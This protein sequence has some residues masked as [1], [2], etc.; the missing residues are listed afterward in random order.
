MRTIS[1]KNRK[2]ID[3]DPYFKVCARSGP[4]CSK[5]ITIEH[6]FIHAGRQIDELFNFLPLCT[7][8]HAV[9]EHQDGGD[10]NKELNEYLALCRATMPDLIKYPRVSW[11]LRFTYLHNKFANLSTKPTPMAD[12]KPKRP[13][14]PFSFCPK[15]NVFFKSCG[16][17]YK[18]AA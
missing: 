18:K 5:R 8:H 10:L 16:C 11:W 7:F 2:A 1:P 17:S 4:N 9:N 15:H 3:A 6:V 13:I 14:G 12:K